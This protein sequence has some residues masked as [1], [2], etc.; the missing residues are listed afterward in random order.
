MVL[1]VDMPDFVVHSPPAFWERYITRR[2]RFLG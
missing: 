2:T 1:F